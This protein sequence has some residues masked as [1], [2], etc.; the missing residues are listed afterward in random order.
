MQ[1]LAL[2]YLK[3]LLKLLQQMELTGCMHSFDSLCS[4]IQARSNIT[5]ICIALYSPVTAQKAAL[6]TAYSWPILMST[7]THTH[8]LIIDVHAP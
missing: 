7:H 8:P 5:G 3:R 6:T 1:T 4:A 2:I